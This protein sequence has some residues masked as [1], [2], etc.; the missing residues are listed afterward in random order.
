[1]RI[2]F[3]P[4]TCHA[5]GLLFFVSSGALCNMSQSNKYRS[6]NCFSGAELI[7]SMLLQTLNAHVL[8]VLAPQWLLKA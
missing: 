2:N 3:S 4:N 7:Q 1:M 8:A 6:L 5:I